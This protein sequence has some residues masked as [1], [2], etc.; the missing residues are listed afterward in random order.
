LFDLQADPNELNNVFGQENF[1]E[2]Q[3]N[4][5]KELAQLKKDLK[6]PEG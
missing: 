4:L 6:V 5:E 3:S 1:A 2:I